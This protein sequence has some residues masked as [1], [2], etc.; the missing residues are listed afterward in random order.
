MGV[1]LQ[2]FLDNH[3]Q[4]LLKRNLYRNFILHLSNLYDF[5]IIA[6]ATVLRTINSLQLILQR[7]PEHQEILKQAWLGQILN[8]QETN[9]LTS[10]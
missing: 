2:M 1:A 10:A 8:K 4:E 9:T 7:S 6:P 5:G 3:G